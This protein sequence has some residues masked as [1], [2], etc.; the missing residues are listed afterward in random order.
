VSTEVP[1]GLAPPEELVEGHGGHDQVITP[2]PSLV[3]QVYEHESDAGGG[4]PAIVGELSTKTVDGGMMYP[5]GIV[6]TVGIVD[7]VVE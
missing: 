4:W 5:D 2:P 7:T 6:L 1:H 3:G